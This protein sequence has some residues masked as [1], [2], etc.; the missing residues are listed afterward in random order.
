MPRGRPRATPIRC[1]T[2]SWPTPRRRSASRAECSLRFAARRFSDCPP[3][4]SLVGGDRVGCGAP[5][6]PGLRSQTGFD[7]H[8]VARRPAVGALQPASLDFPEPGDSAMEGGPAR[9]WP[10]GGLRTSARQRLQLA[11]SG[12]GRR[13]RRC[14]VG[15]DRTAQRG[16]PCFRANSSRNCSA[17]LV[18]PAFTSS[19][20]WR[21]PSTAS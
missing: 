20:P 3:P 11:A 1:S 18:R 6:P 17:G 15:P 4:A 7:R 8:A 10:F 16:T 21:T 19:R 2:R 9:R 14:R 13:S 5:G 12:A